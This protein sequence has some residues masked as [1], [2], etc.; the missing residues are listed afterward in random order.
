[1]TASWR[2]LLRG[3][4]ARNAVAAGPQERGPVRSEIEVR[5]RVPEE[6]TPTAASGLGQELRE[7]FTQRSRELG[8]N[9]EPSVH[10]ESAP[11]TQSVVDV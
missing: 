6:I 3:L 10:I 9:R 5:V 4:R 11:S 7:L 2:E 1:M 8:A